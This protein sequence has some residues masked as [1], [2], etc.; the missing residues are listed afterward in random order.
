MVHLTCFF[1]YVK[2]KTWERGGWRLG[3]GRG[4]RDS[5]GRSLEFMMRLESR[6]RLSEEKHKTLSLPGSLDQHLIWHHNIIQATH[7]S[8]KKKQTGF[9][10]N[11]KLFDEVWILNM[12]P[13]L[14]KVELL[15]GRSVTESFDVHQVT[16]HVWV[17]QCA[18]CH[19]CG[20]ERQ[21]CQQ[22]VK[23]WFDKRFC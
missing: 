9:Q 7:Q 12:T 23:C 8:L 13:T 2:L 21:K 17:V 16:V 20:G 4:Q 11:I 22:H 14:V 3:G 1:L 5:S 18:E 15:V 19:V 10:F 6:F